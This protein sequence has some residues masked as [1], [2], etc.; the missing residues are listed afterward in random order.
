MYMSH[1]D[2]ACMYVR[3]FSQHQAPYRKEK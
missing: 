3:I 2:F 1:K